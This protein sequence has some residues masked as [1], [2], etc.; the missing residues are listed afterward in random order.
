[1]GQIITAEKMSDSSTKINTY[2]AQIIEALVSATQGIV[3]KTS[4]DFFKHWWDDELKDLK[5]KSLD[6]HRLWIA[7]VNQKMELFLGFNSSVK[8]SINLQ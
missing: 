3:P 2:C 6:A 8:L 1:M 5:Q 7:L 4:S